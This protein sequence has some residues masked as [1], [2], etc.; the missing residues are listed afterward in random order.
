[1]RES[2][3]VKTP[4]FHL[5]RTVF[6][7]DSH[8]SVSIRSRWV[9]C[10]W[11]QL[12]RT[13]R[14]VRSRVCPPLGLANP[15]H[16]RCSGA[17][18]WPGGCE[19]GI[20][21]RVRVESSKHLRHPDHFSS[22]PFQLR[23]IAKASL[24]SLPFLGWHLR[25][26]GHLLLDRARPGAATLKQVAGLVRQGKSLIVFPEGTRSIDGHLSPFKRGIFLAA[27]DAGLSVVPL[28]VIGSR[29][30]MRKGR[31]RACPAEVGLVLHDP[32]PT[33]TLSHGDAEGL[34][35]QVR[36]VIESATLGQAPSVEVDHSPAR[37]RS[38]VEE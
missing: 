37:H 31:L 27:I 10:L 19:E 14:R 13:Q 2:P 35:A 5:W 21:L 12:V 17:C 11:G 18:Q 29:H 34:A 38:P 20:D 24:G 3:I 28:S 16:D 15:R 30:V 22:L 9:R 1:M 32:I 6:L 26:T 4:S 23:I 33:A 7:A 25:R 8:D 36:D